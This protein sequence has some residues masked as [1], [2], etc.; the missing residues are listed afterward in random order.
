M[1]A[2]LGESKPVP[3]RTLQKRGTSSPKSGGRRK[4]SKTASGT[5]LHLEDEMELDQGQEE[6]GQSVS[7]SDS[8]EQVMAELAQGKE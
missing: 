4:M 8:D 7:G 5:E 2:D 6:F 3:R 1:P